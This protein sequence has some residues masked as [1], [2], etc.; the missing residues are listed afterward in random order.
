MQITRAKQGEDDF[1]ESSM[2]I[3]AREYVSSAEEARLVQERSCAGRLLT[4]AGDEKK[5]RRESVLRAREV[6]I[7]FLSR[8]SLVGDESDLR[9]V[10]THGE[11]AR[12]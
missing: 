11:C 7:V 12:S 8:G 2:K 1:K 4:K 3:K 10:R 9:P 6:Y 5:K